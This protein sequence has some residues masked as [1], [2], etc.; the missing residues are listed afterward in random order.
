MNPQSSKLGEPYRSVI[1]WLGDQ[2]FDSVLALH[3]KAFGY[4]DIYHIF[5]LPDVLLVQLAVRLVCL[6]LY[7]FVE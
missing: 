4:G 6:W 1:Y 2:A 5:S 3:D 7:S